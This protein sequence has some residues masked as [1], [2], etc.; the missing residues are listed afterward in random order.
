MTMGTPSRRSP[1]EREWTAFPHGQSLL[2]LDSTGINF[3]LSLFRIYWGGN[4]VQVLHRLLSVILTHQDALNIC[5]DLL[6]CE[7]L[8]QKKY[9]QFYK[10]LKGERGRGGEEIKNHCS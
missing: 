8:L 4:G 5:K 2:R 3:F 1:I 10:L 7:L 6:L 9:L